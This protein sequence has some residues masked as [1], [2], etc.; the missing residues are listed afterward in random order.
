LRTLVARSLRFHWRMHLGVVLGAAVGSA[1]LVGALVVGDSVRGSLRHQALQRL[2]DIHF[3]LAPTDRLFRAQLA[4]ELERLPLFYIG[5]RLIDVQ[6]APALRLEGTATRADGAAR[7][8]R[9]QVLGVD[10]RFARLAAD[11]RFGQLTPDSVILNEALAAQLGVQAGDTVVLRV[12]KPSALSRDAPIAPQSGATA[13]LRLQVAALASASAL[14][15]FSLSSSQIAPFNAFVS[16]EALQAAA[17]TTNRAN[18]I[19]VSWGAMASL[20]ALTGWGRTA[21]KIKQMLGLKQASTPV[22]RG[23]TQTREVVTVVERVQL[24]VDVLAWTYI[25]PLVWQLQD[26]ELELRQLPDV[27]SV[28]LGSARIFLDAAAQQAALTPNPKL[29]KRQKLQL[30]ATKPEDRQPEFVPVSLVTNGRPILTYLANL[31]RAG[32]NTTPYSMVTAAG[33]PWTPADMRDDEILVNEWLAQDLHVRPGDTIELSYF[34]P[35]SGARLIEAT[36]RFRVRGVVPMTLPWA[37]RTLMPEFPGIARAERTHDWDAGF[38]LVHKIRDKDEQYWKQYRGTPKA[39]ITLAAGQKLWA[40]RFGTLTAIRWSVPTNTTPEAWAGLIETNLLH[41]LKPE[42]VGLRFEPVRAQALRAADQSQDFGQLFLGFS[43]FLIAAALILMA[44][45]FQFGLEQRA[46]EVGTLLALGFAAG[47]VRRLFLGEGVALA[48]VGGLLGCVAGLGYAW[49]MLKGLATIWREGVNA[50]PL[51]LHV[52]ELTLLL[53]GVV[54]AA[55][56]ALVLALTLRQMARQPAP[57]LLGGSAALESQTLKPSSAKARGAVWLGAGALAAALGVA[58]WAWLTGQTAAAGAFFG[59]GTVV[60]IATLSFAAAGLAALAQAQADARLSLSALG[61]RG[62]TRRRRRSLAVVSLLACGSFAVMAISAFKLDPHR[63]VWRR[64]SGTGGFALIGESTLPIVRDLNTPEGRQFYGLDEATLAGVRFVPLRVRDGDEASCLN[65]NRAQ[66]PR[67]LGVNPDLLAD[68]FRFA[69]GGGWAALKST[70]RKPQAAIDEVPALGDAASIRWALGKQVGQ[71]LDLVD[72]RGQPLRL[73]LVAAL[74]GSILQG[75]LIIDE[76]QF[77]RRFPSET[78]YRM[79]LIDAPSHRVEQVAAVL[80]R[81]FQDVGLELTPAARR[82]A[83][84]NAV[85]NTYLNTF[86]VLGGLGLLLGSAGLAVVLLR[87]ALERRA[88]LGLLV[89]VGFRR[90]RLQ[91]LVLSEHAALLGLGLIAGVVAAAVAILPT[92]L[93]PGTPLPW[94]TLAFTLAG[95]LVSGMLWTWLA[96]RLALR[97]RLLDALRNE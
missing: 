14:G 38:P 75:S 86:Q 29:A 74:V 71:T 80:T 96:T 48:A 41:N 60:L 72:E 16:L 53:G 20:R 92:V 95:L 10:H 36:N 59:A 45:L 91:Q 79:F 15:N 83:Q 66:R 33:P 46:E 67:L 52:S 50:T 55:L 40:N 69:Q 42:A 84:L 56:S 87:N 49:A 51:C 30:E 24:S 8:N 76:A 70:S 25:F 44:L 19:L 57:V 88:E 9:V 93:A 61:V 21:L 26:V 18:L 3:A 2:G 90:R 28:E 94:A 6:F 37:D 7:A 85:Q 31:I 23:W 82:L 43:F 47:R 73:R 39:F 97:G 34:L 89:A 63:D 4:E 54:S 27:G 32:T 5:R 12:R 13:V 62:L 77:T 78:G 22:V 17:G 81:A 68:R 11:V 64:S 35:E 1:A 65:L 58:G